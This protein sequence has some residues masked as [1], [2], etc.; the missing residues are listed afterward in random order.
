MK[1]KFKLWLLVI[2]FFILSI[3]L[4]ADSYA[5]FETN[6]SGEANSTI[7]K[8]VIKISDV[9]ISDNQMEEFS[10]DNFVYETNDNI[11]DGYIAPGRNGYFDIVLDPTGTD[12]AIRYDLSF[13]NEQTYGDNI[14]YSVTLLTGEETI[15]T[16]PNTYSGI[17][18]LDQIEQDT[19]ITLRINLTWESER[20][21]DHNDTILGMTENA[22]IRIPVGISVNQY[23]GETITPYT[24]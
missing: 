5:L 19:K 24:E 17:V 12:V 11:A 21:Y 20:N 23:L 10:V 6:S 22:K 7:G 9:L 13:D 2:L 16:G 3:Y 14:K 15:K 8:W 4:V 18:T 1:T